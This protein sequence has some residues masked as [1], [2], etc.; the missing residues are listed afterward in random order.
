M[1]LGQVGEALPGVHV[2]ATGYHQDPTFDVECGQDGHGVPG[3]GCLKAPG[4]DHDDLSLGRTV[5]QCRPQRQ[6][7]HL[8]GGLLGVTAGLGAQ[9][10]ATATPLG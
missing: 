5:G 2:V 10:H 3:A 6:L 7:D 9:R 1:D 8:L 4:I